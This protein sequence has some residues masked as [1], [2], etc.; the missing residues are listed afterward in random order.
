MRLQKLSVEASDDEGDTGETLDH[1][2]LQRDDPGLTVTPTD[3]AAPPRGTRKNNKAG[4]IFAALSQGEDDEEDD[5][6]EKKDKP[7]PK[8]MAPQ[9]EGFN[10]HP[11]QLHHRNH[12][13]LWIVTGS[14]KVKV[15]LLK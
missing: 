13:D 11:A 15:M 9:G 4:N 12:E 1:Q 14:F 5:E 10:G 2:N 7:R 8:V 6:E 3:S